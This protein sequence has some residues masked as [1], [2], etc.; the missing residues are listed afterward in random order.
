MCELDNDDA[1]TRDWNRGKYPAEEM[2]AHCTDNYEDMTET[3]PSSAEDAQGFPQNA[4]WIDVNG[5]IL[6]LTCRWRG[7]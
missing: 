6:S 1:A 7:A 5:D 2:V 4:I 3:Y